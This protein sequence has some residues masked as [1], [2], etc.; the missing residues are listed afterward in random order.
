[1]NSNN[2]LRGNSLL[3]RDVD[4]DRCHPELRGSRRLTIEELLD[5]LDSRDYDPL[6]QRQQKLLR[7][8]LEKNSPAEFHEIRTAVDTG[9]PRGPRPPNGERTSDKDWVA[10]PISSLRAALTAR[11]GKVG[12][13]LVGFSRAGYSL[14][15]VKLEK[16]LL[17]N[18]V[19]LRK[20][21][22][23]VEV[24]VFGTGFDQ[25]PPT[26][27]LLGSGALLYLRGYH[28]AQT[29]AQ[30]LSGGG[31][32]YVFFGRHEVH[33]AVALLASIIQALGPRATEPP[34]LV[35]VVSTYETLPGAYLVREAGS[36]YEGFII[37][38][39]RGG[40]RGPL[41]G[42]K[43]IAWNDGE[44]ARRCFG[45]RLKSA[46]VASEARQRGYFRVAE[47]VGDSEAKEILDVI[48]QM[49][50]EQPTRRKPGREDSS[51]SGVTRRA[52]R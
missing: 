23:G 8:L 26:L 29:A 32:L 46:S 2:L 47:G 50:R 37:H 18:E 52:R 19:P 17:E 51:S 22:E 34:A 15:R 3:S 20:T 28:L 7:V 1:V 44:F 16:L 13:D 10:Q 48:D 41:P 11:F 5:Q 12:Y 39:E 9:K 30:F 36:K 24:Q 14:D 45:E 43:L 21:Q 27:L 38:E 6:S 35:F 40:S 31:R 49:R 33:D 25:A 42:P 4:G